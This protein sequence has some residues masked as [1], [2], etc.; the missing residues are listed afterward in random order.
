MA[1]QK[2]KNKKLFLNQLLIFS[3]CLKQGNGVKHGLSAPKMNGS[4]LTPFHSG[5]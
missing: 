3:T 2:N 4:G 1:L 5:D